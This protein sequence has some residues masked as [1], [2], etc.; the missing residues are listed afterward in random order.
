MYQTKFSLKSD[1]TV[2]KEVVDVK[3]GREHVAWQPFPA[4]V[5]S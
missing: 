3:M 1:G 2:M 5:E 4:C